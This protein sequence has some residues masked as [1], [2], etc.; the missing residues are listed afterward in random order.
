MAVAQISAPGMESL[1][2]DKIVCE[3]LGHVDKDASGPDAANEDYN[4]ASVYVLCMADRYVQVCGV[5]LS[6]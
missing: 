6:I 4:I 5:V 3:C 1:G 2:D